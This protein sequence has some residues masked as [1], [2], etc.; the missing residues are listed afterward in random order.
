MQTGDFTSVRTASVLLRLVFESSLITTAQI[1][2]NLGVQMHEQS[3]AMTLGIAADA[4]SSEAGP[5]RV[6]NHLHPPE[7]SLAVNRVRCP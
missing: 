5:I 2:S 6:W 4:Q 7:Q 3:G 1:R